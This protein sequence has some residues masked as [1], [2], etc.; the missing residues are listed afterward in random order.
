M[1]LHASLFSVWTP[2]GEFS[3]LCFALLE[4]SSAAENAEASS[5]RSRVYS[6]SL[7][8]SEV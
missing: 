4:M 2:V 7:S 3:V 8:S 1:E 5:V 6:V